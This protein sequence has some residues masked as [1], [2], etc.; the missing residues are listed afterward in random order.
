VK[1]AEI[2]RK[3]VKGGGHKKDAKL[4]KETVAALENEK[5]SKD[6]RPKWVMDEPL[7]YVRRGEDYKNDDSRNTARLL[8]RL[9]EVGE[10][11]PLSTRGTD[12]HQNLHMTFEQRE[13]MIDQYMTQDKKLAG[14]V[15]V[16]E[17]HTNFLDKA[18]E[19]FRENNYDVDDSLKQLK[20]I[21]R[22]TDLRE[23][24]LRPDEVKRFEEGVAKFGSELHSITKHVKTQSHADIV[25]FYYLWKK[26]P[27]GQAIWGNFEGRRGKKEAKRAE[28]QISKLQDDVADDYDDSAF[29]NDKAAE[30]KRGFQCKFCSTKSSR[31]WRRAPATTAGATVTVE[32]NGK[33]TKDKSAQLMVA[34]CRRCAELWRRYA[35]VWEDIDE[36]AKK[37]AVGGGR[38]WKRRIDEEL[39]KELLGGNEIFSASNSNVATSAAHSSTGTPTPSLQAPKNESDPPKKKQKAALEKESGSNGATTNGGAATTAGQKKKLAEKPAGSPQQPEMPKPKTLPCAI[40]GSLDPL[41]DHLSCRECRMSVHR[42]CYG[43]LCDVKG[44]GK[45]VCDMCSNDKNP[46]VSTVSYSLER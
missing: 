44:P 31:Q 25:R 22:R 35:I 21:N 26:T 6:K 2:K 1:P 37:V 4:S 27:K 40:C 45:W 8:W 24:E 33:G 42:H 46:Q 9:P 18:L 34:L 16:K 19:I 28:A 13:A 32:P 41:E 36:V 7:G 5:T 14:G 11:S 15:G 3:Y 38:A 20:T 17:Y 30:K 23:P 10:E 43:V 12:D 39:L 29:D